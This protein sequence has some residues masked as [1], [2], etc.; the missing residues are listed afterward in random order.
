[1]QALHPGM[2]LLAWTDLPFSDLVSSAAVWV[3]DYS[4]TAFDAAY[5]GVPVAY[6]Q[7]DRDEVYGGGSH[8]YQ[9]GYFDYERDGFGPVSESPTVLAEHIGRL[10]VEG[11]AN[12]HRR[13]V[14]ETF[15]PND[16]ENSERVFRAIN[17]L[18]QVQPARRI[19]K[20]ID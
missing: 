20:R 10:A 12:E 19:L 14:D 1:M 17:S 6:L 7:S 8:I 9:R 16:G 11:M 3:T 4:S 2:E 13:R 18:F 5:A 15:L